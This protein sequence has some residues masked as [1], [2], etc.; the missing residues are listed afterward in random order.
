MLA[1]QMEGCSLSKGDYLVA[2]KIECISHPLFLEYLIFF[3]FQIFNELK[4]E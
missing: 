4:K 3:I 2:D 1:E